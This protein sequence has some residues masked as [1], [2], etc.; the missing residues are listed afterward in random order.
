MQQND[1]GEKTTAIKKAS[2]HSDVDTDQGGVAPVIRK[3]LLELE[4]KVHIRGFI[5]TS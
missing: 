4:R 2:D 3:F 1:S 5:T